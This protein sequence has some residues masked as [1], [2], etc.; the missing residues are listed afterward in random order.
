MSAST[1]R[2]A[3]WIIV[4]IGVVIAVVGALADQLGL[5]GDGPDKFGGKQVAALIVGI[6]IA[7]V[8]VVVAFW[9]G[10]A[11]PSDPATAPTQAG[12]GE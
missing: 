9:P 1:R 12:G 11:K 2:V 7:I 8:G 10:G 3:G 4:G 5:G 6:V